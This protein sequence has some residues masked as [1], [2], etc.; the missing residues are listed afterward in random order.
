MEMPLVSVIVPVYKVESY[1]HRC[2]DCILAQT[3][4]NLEIILVDD[5]SPDNCGKIC[6]EY[7]QKDKC[8]KV[9]HKKN[10]GLSD[11]RNAGLDI[12]MGE[13]ITF[14]DSDDWIHFQYVEI[15][16]NNLTKADVDISTCSFVRTP[17]K[18]L[19]DSKVSES[20]YHIY[21]S[22]KAIEQTLYQN[23]LDN[24]AWGKLYKKELFNGLRFTVGRLYEDL[25]FFYKIY[26][27]AVRLVHTD[28]VLYYYYYRTDSIMGVFNRKRLD[29]LDI[30]DEIVDYMVKYHPYIVPAA[31]D[32]KLSANFNM[33]VLMSLYKSDDEISIR[34]CWDN[35]CKLRWESLFNPKVRLKNKLGILVSLFGKKALMTCFKLFQKR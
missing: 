4:A 18:M 29:V 32:R 15:L 25:D 9:I 23:R 19:M 6:D 33:L 10:G 28:A 21:S 31:K 13:Y 26:D 22:E 34:R 24:S 2:V 16:L 14:V 5:G 7:A 1:L 8:I 11:A 30:T 27:R 35:I 20:S 17:E 3:Y 12:A